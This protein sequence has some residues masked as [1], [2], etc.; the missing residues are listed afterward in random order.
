MELKKNGINGILYLTNA[1]KFVPAIPT[2][3]AKIIEK[4]MQY[5]KNG[6]EIIFFKS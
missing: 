4:N 1:P 6:S 5:N 2:P 3:K